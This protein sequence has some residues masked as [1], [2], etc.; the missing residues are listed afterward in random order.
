MNYNYIFISLIILLIILI[1]YISCRNI[2][3]ENMKNPDKP[4]CACIYDIDGTLTNGLSGNDKDIAI[5]ARGSAESCIK[6]GCAIGVATGGNHCTDK[7]T[8]NCAIT[9]YALGF[10]ILDEDDVK[11]ASNKIGKP[12]ITGKDWVRANWN[13]AGDMQDL[14]SRISNPS[15]GILIDDNILESCGKCDAYTSKNGCPAPWGSSQK[16]LDNPNMNNVKKSYYCSFNG[17]SD[18][19]SDYVYIPA[20][21][22]NKDKKDIPG[23]S[24]MGGTG[25]TW[26][27]GAQLSPSQGITDDYWNNAL[28][29]DAIKD[30]SSKCGIIF[31]PITNPILPSQ[32]P[33]KNTCPWDTN[34]PK[35]SNDNDC[36]KW[37]SA[38]CKDKKFIEDYC[39]DNGHCHFKPS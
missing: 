39:K 30:I 24:Q 5:D 17:T 38:N 27:N 18:K 28:E 20:R 2:F 25:M 31:S 16:N 36:S 23:K 11:D 26:D 32:I 35:C 10:N 8:N 21:E 9:K 3:Y 22:I 14:S 34:P 19:S 33:K 29:S 1:L 15:C 6:A 12:I 37:A 4:P 13:K 7:D